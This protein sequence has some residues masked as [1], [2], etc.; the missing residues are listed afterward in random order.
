MARKVTVKCQQCQ[1]KQLFN[2][3]EMTVI[4][5]IS[6]SGRKTRKYFHIKCLNKYKEEQAFKDKEQGE[7]DI[8]VKVAGEIHNAPKPPNLCHQFPRMWY[9]MVQDFRN[10]TS[11]Y[12]RN[13]KKRYKKGIPY[14]IITEAYKM[15]KDS[16]A[17][18]KMDKHFKDTT[19]EVRYCLAIVSGKIPD[20]LKKAERDASMEKVR[21]VREKE[22]LQD[23][24]LERE[25]VYQKRRASYDISDLLS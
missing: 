13:F 25:S 10:G 19:S 4:E 18:A 12:T 16:I 24:E 20:A 3:E 23:M 1:E 7:L 22:E 17:W 5:K 9:H 15:S 8:L 2:E 14:P 6:D 11:R 21:K